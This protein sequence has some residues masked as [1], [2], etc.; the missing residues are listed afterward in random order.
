MCSISSSPRR[1]YRF[2]TPRSFARRRISFSVLSSALFSCPCGASA[3]RGPATGRSVKCRSSSAHQNASRED[4]SRT[5]TSGHKKSI[6]RPPS[7]IHRRRIGVSFLWSWY[8][9]HQ[10]SCGRGRSGKL[11][12]LLT[13]PDPAP[14]AVGTGPLLPVPEPDE[15]A[16]ES[17]FPAAETGAGARFASFPSIPAFPSFPSFSLYPSMRQSIVT[18]QDLLSE[19]VPGIVPVSVFLWGCVLCQAFA[20]FFSPCSVSSGSGVL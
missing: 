17:A 9:V 1:T 11:C 14:A 2:L 6:A 13:A 8:P 4:T 15:P 19:M 20:A 12:A 5:M 10:K 7:S 16:Q 18:L 3:K